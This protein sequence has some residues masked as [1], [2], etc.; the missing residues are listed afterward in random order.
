MGD[1]TQPT[2]DQATLLLGLPAKLG[3]AGVQ[4]ATT[5]RRAAYWAGWTAA[6]PEVQ[7]RKEEQ[8]WEQEPK[9]K[10]KLNFVTKQD[11]CVVNVPFFW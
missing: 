1:Y 2:D 5:R 10:R 3:G 6:A 8:A 4:W 9:N 7:Q 11:F